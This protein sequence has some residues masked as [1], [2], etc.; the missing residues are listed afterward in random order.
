[1]NEREI[2]LDRILREIAEIAFERKD[3]TLE[4]ANDKLTSFSSSTNFHFG[5]AEIKF[6]YHRK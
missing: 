2:K 3:E 6:T 4:N 1:M 5:T